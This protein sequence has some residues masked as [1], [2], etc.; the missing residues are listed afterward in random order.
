MNDLSGRIA[1]ITGARVAVN[2][3][4]DAA[5]ATMVVDG[6][7]SSGGEGQAVQADISVEADVRRMFTHVRATYGPVDLLVNNAGVWNFQPIVDVTVE[8]YRRHYD[9]NVLGTLLVS[10]E[11]AM[12]DDV[13]GGSVVNLTSGGIGPTAP[14]TSLY[15]GTK[16]AVVG[17][18]KVLAL[19]FAPRGIRVNAIAAG[20]IDTAGTRDRFHGIARC[21]GVGRFLPARPCRSAR[22]HRQGGR[23]PR[24]LG[25]RVHDGTGALRRRRPV[26]ALT[27][28]DA[29][30]PCSLSPFPPPVRW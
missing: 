24:R 14:G 15:T 11:F 22:R 20:L 3:G 6:I 28:S 19:E 18:T 29:V 9:T 1:L 17:I 2:Y 8:E 23:L 5:A 30:T 25:R 4:Q 27:G 12:Q 26:V 10:R 13:D 21:G 7:R 16:M